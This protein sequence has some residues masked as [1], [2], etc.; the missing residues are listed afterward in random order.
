MHSP[1]KQQ[2]DCQCWVHCLR[3]PAYAYQM[4]GGAVVVAK[5][6]TAEPTLNAHS[7]RTNGNQRTLL[8]G[9][10]RRDKMGFN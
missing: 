9:A 6:H 4:W 2:P 1:A 7:M 3:S 5:D 8:Q 10:L